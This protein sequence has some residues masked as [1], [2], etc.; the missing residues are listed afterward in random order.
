VTHGR[1]ANVIT[2]RRSN[3]HL[4]VDSQRDEKR[5]ELD[6]TTGHLLNGVVA[7]ANRNRLRSLE[8]VA[9]ESDRSS[10]GMG[11]VSLTLLLTG[12]VPVPHRY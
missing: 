12:I 9:R 4:T 6:K 11:I 8:R 10:A 7:Q 3:V 1:Y 5:L 2:A